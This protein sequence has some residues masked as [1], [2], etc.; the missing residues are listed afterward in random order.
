M[1][2]LRQPTENMANIYV[3]YNFYGKWN[4]LGYSQ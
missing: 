2:E 3:Q 1:I 4:M